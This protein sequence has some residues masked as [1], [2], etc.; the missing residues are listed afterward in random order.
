MDF[1]EILSKAWKTIWKHKI[2]WLFGLLAGCGAASS[3]GG[4]SSGSTS[5]A[6]TNYQFGTGDVHSFLSPSA[7]RGLEDFFEFITEVP[8]WAWIGIGLF[9]FFLGLVFSVMFMMVGTLGTTGVIKGASLADEAD[10]DAKSISFGDIFKGIKP[11]FWKVFLLNLGLRVG[12]M[13]LAM[14]IIVPII[15]LAVCTCF[16]G[17]FLLI[18]IGWFINL[19]VNFTTITILEEGL[20]I[21]PGIKKAWQ[22]I[23]RHLGNVIVMFLILGIGEL[24]AGLVIGLPLI[25]VPMPI[26]LTTSS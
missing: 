15:L 18:P 5:A 24:L 10:M 22:V 17:L 26:F 13:I 11:Y 9:L 7:A 25:A 8:V 14:F 12:G 6:Q 1:G 16:L 3:G 20:G 4:G 2:L 21:F 23:T 19:M